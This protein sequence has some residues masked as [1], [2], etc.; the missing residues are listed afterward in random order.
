MNWII[1]KRCG[2]TIALE[3]NSRNVECRGRKSDVLYFNPAVDGA[4]DYK[5]PFAGEKLDQGLRFYMYPPLT[6]S[7]GDILSLASLIMTEENLRAPKN[8]QETKSLFLR[9]ITID[10][11]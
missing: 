11:S 4:T 9:L 2:I 1:L 8:I 5:F 7:T 6:N 3:I 10:S